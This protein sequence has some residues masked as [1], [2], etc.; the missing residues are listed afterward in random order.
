MVS[1]MLGALAQVIPERVSGDL[2]GTS[3]PNSIGGYSAARTIGATSTSRCRR[4]ATAASTDTTDRA[5]S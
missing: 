3:F 5:R 1:V 2:S 4:V